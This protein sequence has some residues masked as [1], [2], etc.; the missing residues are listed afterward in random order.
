MLIKIRRGNGATRR[1]RRRARDANV[2]LASLSL[3]LVAGPGGADS[4]ASSNAAAP[5]P[6]EA[7]RDRAGPSVLRA[8]AIEAA[9]SRAARV[10]IEPKEA[11]H[12]ES[13]SELPSDAR[14]VPRA[15]PYR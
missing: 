11:P 1:T 12:T 13:R 2:V 9:R 10:R 7:S 8:P 15:N 3:L 6:V 4:V 14:A 5:S